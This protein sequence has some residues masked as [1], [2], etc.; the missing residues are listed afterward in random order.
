MQE[1]YETKEKPKR[2]LLVSVYGRSGDTAERESIKRE[3]EGLAF[4]L[5]LEI[6]DRAAV[7]IREPNPKFGVGA[8]KAQELAEKAVEIQADCIV[9]DS[10]ISPSQ[11]RNWEALAGI[12]VV[13]RQELII[14]IFASRAKTRE[15]ELQV[16][17]AELI[18]TLPRLSHKY[19]ALSR[20]RGGRYG[21]KGA[22]ET[23]LEQDRRLVMARIQRLKT[24]LEAVRKQRNIQRQ[25]REREAVPC[26]ALVGYT[27]AGKSS[28]L[29]ALTAAGTFVEDK[30]FATLDTLTRRL[31]L[32]PG[33][34][35][36]LVD[37]VGFIR[38]LPHALIDAFRST[39]EEASLASAVIHVLDASDPGIDRYFETTM[40]ALRELDAGGSMITVLNKVDQLPSREVLEDLQKR[41]PDA[42]PV[43]TRTRQG[44]DLLRQRI[45]EIPAM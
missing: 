7:H 8:G 25:R 23:R 24:E 40:K 38:N 43:S 35:V 26:C 36:L 1:L 22:G 14:Q 19:I 12:S 30:L 18:Y 41:Y 16:A 33:R 20:Q 13:D 42:V 27:N 39:L 29:N 3:L 17:L 31:E 2:A 6:A 45:M 9:F 5:G 4:T 44:L 10:D 34:P 37:T 28:L 32:E 11:Q 15:A 21:A